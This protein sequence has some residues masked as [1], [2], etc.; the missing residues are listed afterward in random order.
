MTIKHVALQNPKDHETLHNITAIIPAQHTLTQFNDIRADFMR[1]V[2]EVF[3]S[4]ERTGY[5]VS[6]LA[7]GA[8]VLK[9]IGYTFDDC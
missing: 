5:E 3:G 9:Y 8:I 4:F 7:S 2:K 1:T 6:T